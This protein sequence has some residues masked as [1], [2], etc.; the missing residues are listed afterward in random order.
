MEQRKQCQNQN[1][2]QCNNRLRTQKLAAKQRQPRQRITPEAQT[3]GVPA[4]QQPHRQNDEKRASDLI[5]QHDA[6]GKI[7]WKHRQQAHCR[8]RGR[9]A[10]PLDQPAVEQTQ[11]AR[12]HQSMNQLEDHRVVP[13]RKPHCFPENEPSLIRPEVKIGADL[14]GHQPITQALRG[15]QHFGKIR[16]HRRVYR[17]NHAG[18]SCSKTATARIV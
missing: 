14:I 1:S 3:P 6:K 5:G 10:H 4:R 17:K 15:L 8:L 7:H 16:N 12:R 9:F 2:Q 18:E 13:H 11:E